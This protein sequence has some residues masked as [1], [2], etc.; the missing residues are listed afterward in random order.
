MLGKIFDLFFKETNSDNKV[1][2]LADGIY[3]NSPV[4]LKKYWGFFV[5]K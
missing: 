3:K 5:L 4:N 2:K 1:N